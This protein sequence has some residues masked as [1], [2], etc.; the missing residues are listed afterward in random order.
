M[1]KFLICILIL[2]V[3]ANTYS[4]SLYQQ[5]TD[6]SETCQNAWLDYKKADALWK[7]GWW[8][9][10]A[11]VIGSTAFGTAGYIT[12][13]RPGPDPL[14]GE[15]APVNAAPFCWAFFSASAG[16]LIASIPC[17]AVGQTRR[18]AAQGAYIQRY[19]SEPP[20]TFSLQSS[21]NGL[22]IAMNF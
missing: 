1:R 7:T 17:L 16:V 10:G 21:V 3:S 6:P 13:W 22:E 14:P 2:L 11:G 18:K 15:K 4:Q 9:F 20:L 5:P 19:S 8:L 12:L